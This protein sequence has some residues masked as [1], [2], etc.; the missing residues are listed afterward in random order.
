MLGTSIDRADLFYGKTRRRLVVELDAALRERT[1]EATVRLH[2]LIHSQKTP[3]AELGAK[4]NHCSLRPVCMPEL[5]SKGANVRA[6]LEQSLAFVQDA[7][8]R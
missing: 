8:H 3:Q 7:D 1:R 2:T 5:A 6:Y 4:C